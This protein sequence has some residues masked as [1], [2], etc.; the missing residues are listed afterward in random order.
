VSALPAEGIDEGDIPS[1]AHLA[2]E[3]EREREIEKGIEG[4]RRLLPSI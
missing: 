3:R 1:G 4:P 2:D